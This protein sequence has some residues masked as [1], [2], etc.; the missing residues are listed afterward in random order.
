M[1]NKNKFVKVSIKILPRV[2]DVMEFYPWQKVILTDN[3]YFWYVFEDID[4]AFDYMR[5]N[6]NKNL[7]LIY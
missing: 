7:H 3:S 5:E 4:E 2:T 1:K 6:H